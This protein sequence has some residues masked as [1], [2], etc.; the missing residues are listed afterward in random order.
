[1]FPTHRREIPAGGFFVFV[2]KFFGCPVRSH[3]RRKET[4]MRLADLLPEYSFPKSYADLA[5]FGVTDDSREVRF[6]FVFCA[7][8]LASG[9]GLR[10]CTQAA[11]RGAQVMIVPEGTPERIIGL[12]DFEKSKVIVLHHPNVQTIYARL[13]ARFHPGRP[14][15]IVA[16]TGTNGKSSTV[17]FLRDLWTHAG[18][19]AR[20]LGTLGLRSTRTLHTNVEGSFTTFDTKSAHLIASSLAPS[21]TH[22]ALEASSHGLHQ[23]R[24]DGFE[25]EAAVFTNLTQ[26]HLDYHKN[27]DAYFAAKLVLFTERLKARGAAIV[28]ADD[29]HGVYI[30]D[31][32]RRRGSRLITFSRSG[33]PADLRLL[34]QVPTEHGQTLVVSLFGESHEIHAPVAGSFQA[35]NI[36]AALGAVFA[37][38]VDVRVAIEAAGRLES[39]PGRLERA[40]VLHN[41]ASVYVDFAHTPDALQNVLRGLRPHVRKGS[42]LH[43]LFGCGGDRDALKRPI[44]GRIASEL[45][46]VVLVTDDNPR[47]E[48]AAEIRKAV[49]AAAPGAREAGDRYRAIGDA[50][51][52]LHA[53]DVLL[54]AGKGHEDYQILP[55]A[56]TSGN[57]AFGNDGKPLTHKIPF[58][59]SGVVRELAHSLQL[60]GKDQ[61]IL[62]AA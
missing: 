12:T 61:A 28:N 27:M 16:V 9:N 10:Y 29:E 23:G 22:L 14:E 35:E 49:L 53:G 48:S 42:E 45:A 15:T 37:T 39:V 54:V 47:T 40:A 18:F 3:G 2:P 24:L 25:F 52:G 19:E 4:V 32:I 38:G 6:G 59:D 34:W 7:L 17:S 41:G 51:S 44:M 1:L 46:D 62:A 5:I 33:G 56:T 8:P 11:A 26:D 60:I 13:V 55:V 57:A 43:V 50:L 31:E 36:L 20:S 58:S 30:A 21:V